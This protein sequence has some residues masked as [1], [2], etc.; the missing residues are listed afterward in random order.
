MKHILHI[1]TFL[2]MA[3]AAGTGISAQD[4]TPVPVTVSKEKIRVDGK[5]FYSHIVLERQTLYSI[6][7][8]YNVTMEQIFEANPDVK[9]EGLKKNAVILIPCPEKTGYAR[10]GA[11]DGQPDKGKRAA[12]A[13]KKQIIHT[14]KWYEDLDVIAEKYGVTVES[15]M[16]ANGL[17]GRKLKKRQK[18]I[19][20]E[21]GQAA[22]SGEGQADTVAM[23][24]IRP[25]IDNSAGTAGDRTS[26]L[27]AAGKKVSAVL[28]LPFN[29]S[30]EKPVTGSIDFYCGTLMAVREIGNAGT[31]VELSVYDVG[32]G[33]L[34]ITKERLAASDV[35]IGPVSPGLLSGLLMKCPSGTAVV[36]PLD[37]KAEYLSGQYANF[38][39]AP[40]SAE[41]LYKD[42]ALWIREE[43]QPDEEKVIVIREKGTGNLSRDEAMDSILVQ[44]GIPFRTFSYSILEGRD[45][46][47][48]L[49]GMMNTENVNRVLVMSESEAFVNDVIRNLNLLIHE[50]YDI[51]LYGPSKIRSFETIEVDNLHNTKLHTSL[52]YYVDYDKPEVQDFIRQ[53]RALYNTEPTPYAFQGYDIAS[54][55]LKMCADR[56]KGW[57]NAVGETEKSM[58]QSDFKFGKA[59]NEG[60]VN[61]GVRRLIYGPGYSITEILR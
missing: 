1:L 49:T 3:S 11:S 60:Y 38:I 47:E 43:R 9:A 4:Y 30:D 51:V 37:H 24:D 33:E 31:D 59:G 50:D 42:L 5:L 32:N 12:K 35:V 29:A 26:G 54:Y 15:I 21:G 46:Q 22:V 48:T 2:I 41:T 45:I 39:Q 20:P 40:T 53:Y 28:M 17:T 56:G 36:S 8:A 52:A 44:D 55:F 18:L 34:P 25:A 16:Q 6:C 10:Q 14:V 19:I 58:L 23:A 7:K 57:I 27:P 61:T 13:G